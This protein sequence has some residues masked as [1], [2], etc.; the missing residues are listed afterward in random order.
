MNAADDDEEEYEA[1]GP[2]IGHIWLVGC[3]NLGRAM[4]DGWLKGGV[5]PGDMTVINPSA[6]ELPEGV[7]YASTPT[8]AAT[9]PDV[10]VL[11]VK[12]A[13]LA[14]VAEGLAPF[15]RGTL[16]L[17]VLAGVRIER[18]T[19]A[20]PA[21]RVA[22]LL[23]NIAARVGL[24]ITLVAYGMQSGE[25]AGRIGQLLVPLGGWQPIGDEALFDAATALSAS[26]P[27]FLFRYV[28]ALAAAGVAA[29]LPPRLADK[30]ARGTTAGA[31]AMLA[32]DARITPAELA[33]EVASPGG[34]TQAG[35]DVLDRPDALS[36]LVADAVRAATARAGELGRS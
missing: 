19:A 4:L 15:A 21:A 33:R 13:K 8:D 3:G 34:M 12:P 29:G 27:A 23:P 5:A 32:D 6:R 31:A 18:L 17:S 20:F 9:A 14:S 10:I 1:D 28:E 7:R 35:L 30:L 11:A 2:P 16:L 25:D 26:S 36:M 22:R 24:G